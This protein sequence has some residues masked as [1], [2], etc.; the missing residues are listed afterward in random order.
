M[1]LFTTFFQVFSRIA[2]ILIALCVGAL[3]FAISVWILNASLINSIVIHLDAPLSQKAG[4]LMSLLTSFSASVPTVSVVF[5]VVASVLFGINA[6]LLA[7]YIKVRQGGLGGGS[8]V[9]SIGGVV[10][11]FLGIGCAACGTIILT[12]LLGL[13]GGAGLVALLPFGGAEFGV[14]GG[15]A[16][17][18]STWFI[19]EN[20][21]KPLTCPVT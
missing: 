7:Y 2:Y 18:Y 20:I 1:S 12:S 14:L 17:L 4:L 13:L 10:A 16:L 11:S 3:T 21:S 5:I 15:V 19:L 8:T 6:A 9:L